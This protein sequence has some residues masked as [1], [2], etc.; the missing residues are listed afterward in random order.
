MAAER[1][2]IPLSAVFDFPEGL[3]KALANAP[4]E[5]RKEFWKI[6]GIE[7]NRLKHEEVLRGIDRYGNKFQPVKRKLGNL[8]PLVPHGEK[9]RTYYLLNLNSRANGGILYWKSGGGRESLEH[10]SGYHAYR[11]GPRSLPVRDEFWL[12][13]RSRESCRANDDFFE[14]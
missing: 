13:P 2:N 11:H 4:L 1:K 5:K 9:S 10:Y 7:A 6:L 3:S 12:S 14:Y 8:T